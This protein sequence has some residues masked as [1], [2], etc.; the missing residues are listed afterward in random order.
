M[1]LNVLHHPYDVNIDEF[2]LL[3]HHDKDLDVVQ[4][5]KLVDVVEILLNYH[6]PIIAIYQ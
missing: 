2:H 5:V 4:M 3:H 6:H 1:N